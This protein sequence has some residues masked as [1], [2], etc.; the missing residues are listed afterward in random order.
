[1]PKGWP[2]VENE[3][4][5]KEGRGR[6]TFQRGR[7]SLREKKEGKKRT[8]LLLAVARTEVAT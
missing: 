4:D 3:V 5:K 7:S 8:L 2:L 6:D 1:M